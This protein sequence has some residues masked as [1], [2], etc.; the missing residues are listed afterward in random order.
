MYAILKYG[1]YLH[2]VY[3][4][5]DLDKAKEFL[6]DNVNDDRDEYHTWALVEVEEGKDIID[7]RELFSLKKP[8][9]DE[10][11]KYDNDV[12]GIN[13]KHYHLVEVGDL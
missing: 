3:F 1:V 8:I 9:N 10:Y 13:P 7:C 4:V 5:K 11:P 2:D 12:V 6:V